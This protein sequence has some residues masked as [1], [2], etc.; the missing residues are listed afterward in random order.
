MFSPGSKLCGKMCETIGKNS[1][2]EPLNNVLFTFKV[3]FQNDLI[4]PPP[5][6]LSLDHSGVRSGI[7]C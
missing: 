1:H 5:R 7:W 2:G 4:L 6:A 3:L